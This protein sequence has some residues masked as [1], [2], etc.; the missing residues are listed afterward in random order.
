[1]EKWLALL[2][3]LPLSAAA[4][5]YRWTD[6]QGRVHFS[7]TPPAAMS[8]ERLNPQVNTFESIVA[9]ADATPRE[10]GT[11][12]AVVMYATSWCPYCEKARQYFRQHN[13]HYTEYDI[14]RD[15][16]ARKRY[17][18]LGGS[19]VPVILVGKER[20]NGF[21]AARFGAM[22]RKGE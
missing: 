15:S 20:M 10:K 11:P 18:S 8:A 6:A 5:I 9:P 17:E 12:G 21:S 2:W 22:Y 16:H 19:G 14:E 13:I 3:V 4:E 7:D 1:M